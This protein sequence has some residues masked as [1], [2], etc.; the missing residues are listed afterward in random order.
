MAFISMLALAA[1]IVAAAPAQ[2]E[3]AKDSK[4]APE[5]YH[6]T[7]VDTTGVTG[8]SSLFELEITVDRYSTVAESETFST[9]YQKRKQ[10]GLLNAMQKA[11]R[12]GSFRVPGNLSYEIRYAIHFPTRD[13]RRRIVLVTDRPVGFLEASQRPRSLD[14]PFLVIELRVDASGVGEG[15]IMYPAAVGFERANQITIEE[16]LDRSIQLTKV[17][18]QQKK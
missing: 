16:L 1:A 12:I 3:A 11:P 15:Q 17:R 6:A 13:N 7:A 10:E 14:Y 9:A 18:Q 2:K 5:F 8:G 4:P